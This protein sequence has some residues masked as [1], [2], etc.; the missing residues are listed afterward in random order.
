MIMS[1]LDGYM[2]RSNVMMDARHWTDDQESF[3]VLL[4]FFFCTSSRS[5]L[6]LLLLL[7]LLVLLTLLMNVLERMSLVRNSFR[8]SMEC[9]TKSLP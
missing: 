8:Q 4:I 9:Q 3:R 1:L 6:L 7:L 2:L 5:L